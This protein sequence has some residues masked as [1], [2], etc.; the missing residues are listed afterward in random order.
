MEVEVIS[1][2]QTDGEPA[3]ETLNGVSILRVPLKHWR[4][5]KLGYMLQYAAFISASFLV[6]AVRSLTRRYSLVHVHNMPD[7]LVLSALIP[8]ICGAKV[9]LDLHDPMPELMMTIFG[10]KR[11]SFSVRALMRLEKWSIRLADTVLTPNAAFERLFAARSCPA[12]KLHVV[13]NSPDENI[14]GYQDVGQQSPAPGD[15]AK[16]FVIMYHGALVERHGL[17]LV[18]LALEAIRHSIPNAELRVFG[19]PTPYVERVMELVRARGLQA[20]VRYLGARN[21]EQ[22]A[23]AIDGCDVGVIP[24]RGSVFTEINMPT[25]IFEY[26]V[27]GKPVIAPRTAGIQDYFSPDDLIFF[28]LGDADDLARKIQYVFAHPREAQAAVKRGQRVYRAHRWSEERLGFATL[29]R[30]LLQVAGKPR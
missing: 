19:R 2:K 25:R 29:V 14:F 12:D 17:D 3:H 1:L 22:I 28:E 13:M 21:L 27:R 30:E 26:L 10:L 18:V 16:P 11:E 8:K 9:I 20:A 23:E 24:N 4:G 7:V 6:L 15:P 5:G